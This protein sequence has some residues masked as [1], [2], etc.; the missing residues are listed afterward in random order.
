[1]KILILKI[2]LCLALSGFAEPCQIMVT[3]SQPAPKLD[4]GLYVLLSG[5]ALCPQ[6]VLALENRFH[7]NGWHISSY[8]VANRGRLNPSL[9]SFSFFEEAT[10]L[11]PNGQ[12]GE[13]FFGHFTD[14]ID[15]H[16]D[17]DQ[18]PAAKKLLV[19]AIAFDY[20]KGLYNF[21]ELIGT[22]TGA[23]WFY[24]GDSQ[25][26]LLDNAYL[27]RDPPRGEDKFGKRMR[28]SAC[29]TSGGPIMKELAVPHN[30]WWRTNHR[31]T[32]GD[33]EL[34]QDV[35]AKVSALGDASAFA[36]SVSQGMKKLFSS[37]SY[38][39]IIQKRSLQEIVRPL[40]CTT[41]IN[42]ISSSTRLRDE[43][44]EFSLPPEF[45]LNPLLGAPALNFKK[46]DYQALTHKYKL[47]FPET[48]EIDAD[49]MWLAPIISKADMMA[50][51]GL[52]EHG[53]LS[54]KVAMDIL[55][56]DFTEP[57]FSEPRCALLSLV[58]KTR[59]D[60]WLKVFVLNLKAQKNPYARELAKNINDANSF[61]MI[62]E[63][64]IKAHIERLSTDGALEPLFKTLMRKRL[65]VFTSEISKNPRGQILEPGFRVIFP[66]RS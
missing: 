52:I 53:V 22:G 48:E 16:I 26:A 45:V 28:C 50:I 55:M 66:E 42:L 64:A 57:T 36:L 19:E 27:Y 23:T 47:K 60:D 13:V 17:L 10:G 44:D 35:V 65:E 40:F 7:E 24:R 9:G 32:F 6:H 34:S 56:V 43:Q 21:Y 12:T 11:L 8:M 25:D 20:T 1:M 30:D 63:P 49:Y 39:E 38:Q 31:L 37:P 18:R 14:V 61:F 59:S 29:H 5:R 3:R 4:D 46:R 15:G 62:H 33:H 54:Q 41:E 58:P 51:Q 2:V